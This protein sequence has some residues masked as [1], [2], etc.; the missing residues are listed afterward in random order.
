M[1]ESHRSEPQRAQSLAI[2]G[3][4]LWSQTENL[5]GPAGFLHGLKQVSL[6]HL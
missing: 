4:A 3:P 2:G 6:P 1:E 5:N